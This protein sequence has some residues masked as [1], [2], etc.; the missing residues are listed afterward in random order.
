[1]SNIAG[2][3]NPRFLKNIQDNSM[4]K[5]TDYLS[6]W[7]I[8]LELFLRKSGKWRSVAALAIETMILWQILREKDK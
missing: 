5:D 6:S 3:K 7:D 1:M 8:F 2:D 4:E